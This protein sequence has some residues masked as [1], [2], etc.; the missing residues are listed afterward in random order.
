MKEF[1]KVKQKNIE[2]SS[3][4]SQKNEGIGCH[5]QNIEISFSLEFQNC[6]HKT[7]LKEKVVLGM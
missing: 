7:M 3:I 5:S 4:N 1:Y 2:F 6:T